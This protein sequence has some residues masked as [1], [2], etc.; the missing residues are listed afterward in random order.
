MKAATFALLG[1]YAIHLGLL[2]AYH[3]V[4]DARFQFAAMMFLIYC[5][6]YSFPIQP[7]EGYDVFRQSKL[8]WMC[9]WIPILISFVKSMPDA[10]TSI[11]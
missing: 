11:L 9:I 10:Y 6:I 3:Y 2:A 1:T 8:V 7:L 5:F 4:G